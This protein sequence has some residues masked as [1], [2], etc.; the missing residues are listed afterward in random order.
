MQFSH[1]EKKKRVG[2]GPLLFYFLVIIPAGAYDG[3]EL[4]EHRREKHYEY[5]G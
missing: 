5:A 4:Y 2:Y 1:T 3:L